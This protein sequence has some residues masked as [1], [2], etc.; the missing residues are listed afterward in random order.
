MAPEYTFRFFPLEGVDVADA[1]GRLA[2][3]DVNRMVPFSGRHGRPY[4]ETEVI[5]DTTPFEVYSFAPV[6]G[7]VRVRCH[8]QQEEVLASKLTGYL[9]SGTIF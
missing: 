2:M 7:Y 4:T 8:Q 9:S 5:A 3:Q 1:A 6:R